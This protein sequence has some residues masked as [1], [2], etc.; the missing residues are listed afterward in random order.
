MF[1]FLQKLINHGLLFGLQCEFNIRLFFLENINLL[2][3]FIM[4][5]QLQALMFI[6]G[7]QF[8]I[9][10]FQDLIIGFHR[11]QGLFLSHEFLIDKIIFLK[12]YLQSFKW[13]LVWDST[14]GFWYEIP[15][16][17]LDCPFHSNCERIAFD[18]NLIGCLSD[19][20]V[21]AQ[22]STHGWFDPVLSLRS[23]IGR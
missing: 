15:H 18:G 23:M 22:N 3:H 9:L 16:P 5:D 2:L 14:S 10:F 6:Q 19:H 13:H 12:E 21:L 7:L 20:R 8:L 11:I 17:S 1:L 4:I